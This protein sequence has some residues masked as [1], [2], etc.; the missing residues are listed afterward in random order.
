MAQ[1]D[2]LLNAED[3]NYE[4]TSTYSTP[5]EGAYVE[6]NEKRVVIVPDELKTIGVQYDNKVNRL[7]FRIPRH[8]D[9]QDLFDMSIYINY[10]LP[11]GTTSSHYVNQKTAD[12]NTIRFD[13]VINHNVTQKAGNIT[14]LVCAKKTDGENDTIHW[15]SEL[16]KD[17]RV[18]EGLE[19][20]EEIIETYPETIQQIYDRIDS[21]EM[22][23]DVYTKS[24]MDELL[25]LRYLKT[26]TYSKQEVD[27]KIA[28]I[29]EPDLSPYSTKTEVDEKIAAIPKPD[30]SPYSTKAEVNEALSQRYLKTET[31]SK[32]EVDQKIADIPEPD[33]STYSTKTEVNELLGQRYL[34]TETYNKTEVNNLLSQRYL[35]TETYSKGEVDR[36]I[37]DIPEPDLSS[38]STKTEVDQK[39]AAIP[40]P[41]MSEYYKKTET[42]NKGE[43]D[44]KIADIP[45]PDLSPYSTKTEVNEALSQRYLKTETYSKSEVDEKIAAIPKPDMSEYYKKTEVE[46]L[47]DERLGLI[48]NG[49]Y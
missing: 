12:D 3:L 49:S 23:T 15:N 17:I 30:L 16:C 32:G 44:Q 10:K 20:D 31:Y 48:E 19:C 13:W 18:S 22:I 28:D 47:I 43:V 45:E 37:E 33:L 11:D 6:V 8:W 42:Y 35:K 21:L 1:V 24:E 39:I 46:T 34:K 9:G 36:K 29:P 38:Y 41:D 7:P 40:K 14:F 5:G 26:E 4:D 2:E 27:Q 25:N